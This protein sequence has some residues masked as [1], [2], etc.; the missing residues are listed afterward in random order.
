VAEVAYQVGFESPN[1][2]TRVFHQEFGL[3]P[4]IFR[5]QVA[6]GGLEKRD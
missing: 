4:S 5:A 1:Y 2:F 6:A 3:S